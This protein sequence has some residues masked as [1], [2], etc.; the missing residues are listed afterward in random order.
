MISGIVGNAE[1]GGIPGIIEITEITEIAEITGI[2]GIAEISGIAET[3]CDPK[4][5]PRFQEVIH[6]GC[7]RNI[8]QPHDLPQSRINIQLQSELHP[9]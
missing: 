3:T 5:R 4:F 7:L 2:P 8:S 9:G 1:I 6:P